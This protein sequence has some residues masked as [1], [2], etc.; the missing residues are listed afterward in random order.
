MNRISWVGR[1][2]YPDLVVTPQSVSKLCKDTKT[3]GELEL[4]TPE[5][6]IEE[7]FENETNKTIRAPS[8]PAQ[9]TILHN[10]VNYH[11]MLY[12]SIL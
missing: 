1:E 8:R 7:L 5:G 11:S 9:R 4:T 2:S 10:I 12:Y 3:R 6:A